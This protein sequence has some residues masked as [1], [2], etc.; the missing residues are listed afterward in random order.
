MTYTELE[1]F[2]QLYIRNSV[3]RAFTNNRLQTVLLEIVDKV[4]NSG[5]GGALEWGNIGGS[6]DDQADLVS[7]LAS[8]AAS[9]H[10]HTSANISDFTEAVQDAVAALLQQGSNVTL[11]YNDASNTLTI[12]AAGEGGGS[13]DPETIRDTIGA[14]LI[15]VGN[16]GIS[17]NDAADTI[18]ISTSATQNSTDAALRDRSTHTGTQSADTITDGTTNKT[19]LATERTK[20]SGIATGATAN[21]TDANLRNRANHTGTQAIST[22]AGLQTALDEKLTLVNDVVPDENLPGI[23]FPEEDFNITGTTDKT[24][25]INPDRIQSILVSYLQGLAGFAEGKVLVITSEGFAWAEAG[26]EVETQLPAPVISLTVLDDD[27]IKI[28]W[29]DDAAATNSIVQMSTAADFTGAT[30]I[31]NGGLNT[32]TRSGLTPETLYYFRVKSQASGYIDSAWDSDSATTEEEPEAPTGPQELPTF[33]IQEDNPGFPTSERIAA[34]NNYTTNEGLTNSFGS[35]A[36]NSKKIAQGANGAYYCQGTS[37]WVAMGLSTSP[38]PTGWANSAWKVKY[39]R[40]VDDSNR[41][42]TESG[43]QASVV[44]NTAHDFR[45][46]K[47]NANGTTATYTIESSSDGVNW[48]V[49]FTSAYTADVDLYPAYDLQ[50]RGGSSGS[51]LVDPREEGMV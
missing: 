39:F 7:V 45:I 22:V 37:L 13:A 44:M 43:Q 26:A 40:N 36:V 47:S 38:T 3:I 30:E 46:K 11:S 50:R 42:Y 20:L 14:A 5:G 32:Y 27:Q 49:R 9:S 31:Y 19:F 28:D 51:I 4:K 2:I 41:M 25:N 10:T 12:A 16:I 6:V 21:D 29:T 33:T 18:T 35:Y 24:V 34:T 15:P 1:N 23:E 17:I 48:T 8:K